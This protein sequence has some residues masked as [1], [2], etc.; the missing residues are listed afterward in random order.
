LVAKAESRLGDA[1][2][3]TVLSIARGST[4]HLMPDA[5]EQLQADDISDFPSDA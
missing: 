3:L 5:Q 1:F 4:T 2:G